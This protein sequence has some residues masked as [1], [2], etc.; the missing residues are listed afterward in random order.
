VLETEDTREQSSE[1]G[2]FG[3]TR[4]VTFEEVLANPDDVEINLAWAR[5]QVARG[6]VKGA[7]GTFERILLIR[8]DL[9]RVRLLYAIVLFRLDNLD[10]AERE[11][12]T[13]RALEMPAS[14]RA[15]ID[16]Y[17][18]QI[19]L[20]RKQTRYTLIVSL[21][22]QY[23]WNRNAAPD[24]NR[25]LFSDLEAALTGD[26]QRAH[27]TA[28]NGLTRFSVNHD[29]GYQARHSLDAALTVY[30][31]DQ[32]R[33]DE[34]DLQAISGEFGGTWDAAPLA[35]KP[36]LYTRYITLAKKRYA[37]YLGGGVR[38]AF[39]Y[40]ADTMLY[41]FGEA[42][43]QEFYSIEEALS[44]PE[45]TGMQFAAGV[46][47]EYVL[48][49]AMRI[50][51]ELTTTSKEASR[52]YN[53]YHSNKL[54]LSHTWLLGAGLFL[55]SSVS[56]ERI[57]YSANDPALSARTRHDLFGRARVT[58]AALADDGAPPTFLDDVIVTVSAEAVRQS[59]N[60][61]NYTYRNRR[62]SFDFVKR[63]EF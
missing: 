4:T 52:N 46:G 15:E 54:R 38:G 20:R 43:R 7:A 57:R 35:I 41:A 40:D 23:D 6:D 30:D 14:L 47:A 5:Q 11:L 56:G 63:W 42:E 13:V 45:R 29:L 32:S 8:P 61:P 21:G 59:S 24:D 55:T 53:A 19:A 22:G 16:R 33:R 48:D 60:L 34:L 27:D 31:S 44:A 18:D 25:V 28:I 10:E 39:R 2:L 51:A 3:T 58:L 36:T 17:L 9:P 62:L 37:E 49:P 12:R 1:Q 50:A 26:D